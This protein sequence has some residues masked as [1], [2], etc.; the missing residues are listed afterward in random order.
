M[1][2]TRDAV[3]TDLERAGQLVEQR[4]SP[5]GMFGGWNG[6]DVLCHLAA[7][8]RLVGA[9]LRGEAE[10]RRPTSTELY[11][12]ELRE[13]ELALG[14]LDEVNAAI[15]RECVGLSYAE[16]LAFWRAM[17][18][19]VVGQAARLT[20]EQLAAP[21]PAYPAIWSRPHVAEVVGALV[22]HYA[23]HMVLQ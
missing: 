22:A 11:G 23:G 12:R 5:D 1:W 14:G 17:H 8:A 16:A 9:L 18:A 4:V 13:E 10:G 19:Q 15:Q 21:G 20:D 2:L 3:L 7:Y 6:R